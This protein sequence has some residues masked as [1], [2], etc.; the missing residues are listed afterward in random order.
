[1]PFVVVFGCRRNGFENAAG[2]REER[3]QQ[4][5]A[6]VCV[7]EIQTTHALTTTIIKCKNEDS[8]TVSI[9]NINRKNV[10]V[11]LTKLEIKEVR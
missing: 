11:L 2:L 9:N 3:Q 8:D 5:S 1:M 4:Q 10:V 6:N 7:H